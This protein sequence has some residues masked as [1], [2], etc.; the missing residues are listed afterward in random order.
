M[1]TNTK[2]GT[3]AQRV[4]KH[5]E[6]RAD[7]DLKSILKGSRSLLSKPANRFL[8][9]IV[10][11]R[12]AKATRMPT[13]MGGY[14]EA[15]SVLK[16]K[17]RGSVTVGTNGLGY[18]VVNPNNCGPCYDV[19]VAHVTGPTYAG[20]YASQPGSIPGVGVTAVYN[21][22][23]PYTGAS[24]MSSQSIE[25]RTV[26]SGCYLVPTGSA[27]DQDGMVRLFEYQG[28]D[29]VLGSGLGL[30]S[31][32]S[33]DRTRSVRGIQLGDPTVENVINWHPAAGASGLMGTSELT[34]AANDFLFRKLPQAAST[35]ITFGAY[36]AVISG[37]AGTQYDFEIYTHYEVR[38]R[39]VLDKRP[40]FYDSRG[41]DL[42]LSGIGRKVISGWV[43]KSS[44]AEDAYY[45]SVAR[46]AHHNEDPTFVEKV[47]KTVTQV[48]SHPWWKT[49]GRMAKEIAGFIL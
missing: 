18:I 27:T 49:L 4:T 19:P 34:T 45:H 7:A 22:K 32:E 33:A 40:C 43:G 30:G 6:E 25:Y 9:A 15:S 14:T 12:G 16:C 41:M 10:D 3:A 13:L 42:V 2:S 39:T 1:K 48:A 47:G 38:G 37:T 8:E 21:S 17:A 36:I 35:A 26:A 44:E 31:I 29:E 11:P 24:A 23:A 46:S 28:H 20:N 5:T